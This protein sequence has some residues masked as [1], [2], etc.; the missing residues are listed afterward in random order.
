MSISAC[1]NAIANQLFTSPVNQLLG[2]LPE[3]EYQSLLPHL[4]CVALPLKTAIYNPDE[5]IDYAYFPNRAMISLVSTMETGATTEIGLI[6]NEG[7]VGLPIILGGDHT[8]HLAFVQ[9]EGSAM[10]IEADILKHHF[11][12]SQ[13]LQKLLL[14]YTQARLTQVAQTAAC[15]SQHTIEKRLARWLLSVQDCILADELPLTQEAIAQM[16]G[17]RR[18][19]VTVAAGK[20]QK[21]GMIYYTRGKIKILNQEALEAT[22]CEC[23]RAI[24][25]EFTRLLGSW[26]G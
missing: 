20:L 18:A 16:L 19:G 4:E 6:G 10:R 26:R 1:E 24:K 9:V 14:L 11:Q 25:S 21:A 13:S 17:T 3:A 2:A 12:H 23:H 15:N 5:P 22:A 8:N 7:M